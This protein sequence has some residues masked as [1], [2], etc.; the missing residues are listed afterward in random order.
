MVLNLSSHSVAAVKNILRV[1]CQNVIK[2][3]NGVLMIVMC[4]I[5]TKLLFAYFDIKKTLK[6]VKS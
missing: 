4:D 3:L 6:I 1:N 2:N 5:W